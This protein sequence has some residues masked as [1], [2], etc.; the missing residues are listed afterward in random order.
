MKGDKAKRYLSKV[1]KE[2]MNMK[3]LDEVD[4]DGEVKE[5]FKKITFMLR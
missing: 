3:Y 4:P 5:W 2:G 1:F